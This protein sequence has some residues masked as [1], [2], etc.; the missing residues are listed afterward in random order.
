MNRTLHH[1]KITLLFALIGLL[2]VAVGWY[3]MRDLMRTNVQVEQLYA[4][5]ARGLDLIGD[6][7]YQTQEV[8]R[9]VLYTFTTSDPNLQIEYADQSHE[10]EQHIT[11][12]IAAEKQH[13]RSEQHQQLINKFEQDWHAYLE[14]RDDV[15]GTILQGNIKEAVKLDQRTSIPAFNQV[16]ADLQSIKQLYK[17]DA[18]AQ[19]A[20]VGQSFNH[21]VYKVFTIL[22]VTLLLAI[23]A[24]RMIQRGRVLRALERANGELS[25]ALLELQETEMALQEAK[26]AAEA[27]NQAKSTFLANMSHELRTPL[28]AIIGYSEM[29]QEEA[30][31]GGQDEFVP[32]LKKIQVAGRHLLTLINDILDLSKIE[33]GKTELYLETFSLPALVEEIEATIRP[34]AA[35]NDNELRVR[36]D[37]N[38][39]T[40][41]ADLTKVRQS[42]LNLLSNACKF[43]KQGAVTFDVARER[44]NGRD[45]VVFRVA[46]T[47]IGISDE[48]MLKLLQPF[49]QA[50]ASTT[51]QFGGTGLGLVITRKFCELMGGGITVESERGKGSVFT[52][53]LP[54]VVRD[55]R[56]PQPAEIEPAAESMPADASTVLI[57]DDDPAARELLQRTLNKAGFRVE[58]AANAE[59]GLRLARALHPD[60]ITLDVMMPGMDGWAALAVLKADPELA[61]IPVIMLSIIDD[62][63]KGY[64]LG[65]ADYMTKPIDREQLVSILNK[66]RHADAPCPALV[67][68]DDDVTRMLLR[69][70]L[71]QEGWQV[72]EA[73]NGR[74]ALAAV[75]AETPRLILLDLMMPEMD[76]FQF[77]EE[78]HR[79][80]ARHAIPIVV[81]TAKDITVEDRLR[82]SGYVEKILEKGALDRE[83]LLREVHELVQACVRN[84][85]AVKAIS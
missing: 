63:N 31:D 50:D 39:G 35:K 80:H 83:E 36:V 79:R 2:V 62:K 19:L 67:V 8:R 7:Q 25:A 59:D 41:R 70:L 49:S 38:L 73:T 26:E 71:E 32:D 40:M 14:T 44:L 51:R 33:A 74:A 10:A 78:L 64:A 47:G 42:L 16:R 4:G 60:A 43:T 69:H 53:K 30:E 24:I 48:Q 12:I 1:Y 11:D 77:V 58:S 66:Y 61:D 22:F 15:L 85:G 52:I 56:A 21:T 72:R 34:L 76:G 3:V 9:I 29:L 84:R 5:T 20:E 6:L 28:N 27:A 37:D 54:A 81:I 68:E 57:V 46:D 65:A 23:I 82:L 75:A 55:P 18:E 45:F 13:P 17:T